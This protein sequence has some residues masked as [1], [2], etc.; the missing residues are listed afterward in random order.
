[1]KLDMDFSSHQDRKHS[2][3]RR[4]FWKPLFPQCFYPRKKMC[5]F[6]SN[7]FSAN[8][9]FWTS[10]RFCHLVKIYGIFHLPLAD[11]FSFDK[12]VKFSGLFLYHTIRLLTTLKKKALEKTVGKGE[13]ADVFYSIKESNHH[14]SNIYFASCKCFQFGHVQNF[15]SLVKC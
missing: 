6:F 14:F 2:G 8:V 13:N 12:I 15:V 7:I 9:L 11:G 4:I 3:R 1:M 5:K 10:L